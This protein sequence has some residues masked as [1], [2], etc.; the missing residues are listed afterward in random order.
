MQRLAVVVLAVGTLCVVLV[1]VVL[2]ALPRTTTLPDVYGLRGMGAFAGVVFSG[3]GAAIALRQPRNSVG[4]I[5]L[6]SGVFSP[7][8]E[9]AGEYASYALLE[10]EATLPGAAWAVWLTELAFSLSVAPLVTYV[11]LVFPDG[12]LPSA[13]WRPAAWY[14]VSALV[15]WTAAATLA[16]TSVGYGLSLPN[17]VWFGLGISLDQS[18]RQTARAILLAPAV[19]LSG[20]AFVQRFRTSQGVERQQLKWVAYA[21][22]I[23]V[24]SVVLLPVASPGQ[25]QLEIVKQLAVM[26]VPVASAIAIL[27]YH[28]YDIDALIKRTLVYGSL[29][30]TLAVLYVSAIVLSQQLLR[31][32]T[33]GSDISVAAST[34]LVVA[35]FQPIR[36]RVQDFVDRR[37]YRSRYDAARTI[38]A[39]SGRL[40]GDVDLDSVRAD[41]I[42]VVHDT[43]HPA[44]ASVWLR[45]TRR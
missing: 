3:L 21:A 16:F 35:L 8:L 9:A 2:I 18:G 26:T 36:T 23:V 27:R 43:I 5:F 24:I 29:S 11:L 37:F 32:F 33:G 1:D 10:R 13:R 22:T 17:P 34:L 20:A 15:V 25:K 14:A 7:L 42:G 39:F 40:R 19:I 41:L 30:A 6:V 28:L 38:D 31:G 44:H 45:A 4:W 12:R